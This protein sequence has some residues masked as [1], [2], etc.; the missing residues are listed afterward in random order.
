MKKI[1]VI[2]LVSLSF[3]ISLQAT[4]LFNSVINKSIDY[5]VQIK[6]E[7]QNNKQQQDYKEL[8]KHQSFTT[9][10]KINNIDYFVKRYIN[11]KKCDQILSNGGYFTTC[12]NYQYKS[13]TAGYEILDGN[14]V[15]K[16]NIKKRPRFY[17]DSNIPRRYQTTYSDYIHSGFDRGHTEANDAS[18][19]YSQRSQLSTYVM[20]NITPQYPKTNRKSY[21]QVEKE[22]R[23]LAVK[24]NKIKSVTLVLFSNHPKKLGRSRLSI[25]TGYYKIFYNKN[26]QKC[27]YIP[28]DNVIY[29]LNEMKINCS[30]I[31]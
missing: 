19:D 20:S 21:L 22:A 7:N 1:L 29:Q 13:M 31:K 14:L 30:L 23:K 18:F 28:N 26:F 3:Q 8:S 25:P 10:N 24:Y 9:S 6:R 15:Y 12:Y 17:V 5:L 16:K 4:S 27:Y 11:K 2:M